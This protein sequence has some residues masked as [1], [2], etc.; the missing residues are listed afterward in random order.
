MILLHHRGQAVAGLF[1]LCDIINQF[2]IAMKHLYVILLLAFGAV[3]NS[4]SNANT[5][6]IESSYEDNTAKCIRL[7]GEA[8][9]KKHYSSAIEFLNIALRDLKRLNYDGYSYEYGMY[10][11]EIKEIEELI[12]YCKYKEKNPDDNPYEKAKIGFFSTWGSFIDVYAYGIKELEYVIFQIPS[13]EVI[14]IDKS[15]VQEFASILND[16]YQSTMIMNDKKKKVL[17]RQFP[18]RFTL[19]CWDKNSDYSKPTVFEADLAKN[20]EGKYAA[21]IYAPGHEYPIIIFAP[22]EDNEL[23][24]LSYFCKSMSEANYRYLTY[25]KEKVHDDDFFLKWINH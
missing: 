14:Y 19:N 7:A 18:V 25:S 2:I 24:S 23:S 4:N 12:E 8:I 16:L 1:Y 15:K 11:K 10:T 9:E 17:T 22:D 3:I 13:L 20:P 5:L 21:C 6:G